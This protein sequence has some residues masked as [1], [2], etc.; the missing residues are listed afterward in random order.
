M[1]TGSSFPDQTEQDLRQSVELFGESGFNKIAGPVN[2]HLKYFLLLKLK[3][4]LRGGLFSGII[5]FSIAV[6]VNV[7]VLCIIFF[8][9]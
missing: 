3:Q 8:Y 1:I 4:F 6:L 5:S 9:I 7:K 2:D